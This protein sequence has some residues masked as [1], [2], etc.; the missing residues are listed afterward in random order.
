MTRDDAM[1]LVADM[2]RAAAECRKLGGGLRPQTVGMD[3]GQERLVAD[4]LE[5]AARALEGV[6]ATKEDGK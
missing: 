4:Y 6:I 5:R 3:G 1:R 2:R